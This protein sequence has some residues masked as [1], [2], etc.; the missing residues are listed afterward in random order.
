[1]QSERTVVF[2]H[3]EEG[4]VG[5]TLTEQVQ[6]NFS[7]KSIAD[8]IPKFTSVDD[9]T[10]FRA[11]YTLKDKDIVVHFFL[12][13]DFRRTGQAA[14]TYWTSTFAVA[15]DSVAQECFQAT[16]PRLQ[17]KYT[18][19]LKS[20]WL[21]ARGYDHLIDVSKFMERFFDRLDEELE[22]ALALGPLGRNG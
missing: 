10:T 13:Q 7:T 4:T 2:G 11:E 5:Q 1:M 22:K 8:G 20:W 16:Q 17:A 14:V 12:P 15:L 18:E 21:R 3:V 9:Y 19:E 6:D